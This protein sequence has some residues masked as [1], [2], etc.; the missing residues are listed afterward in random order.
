M[1]KGILIYLFGNTF[2]TELLLVLLLIDTRI[3]NWY[4]FFIFKIFC[5]SWFVMFYQFLLYNWYLNENFRNLAF[6]LISITFGK[7]TFLCLLF[8]IKAL[9]CVL[10]SLF[11]FSPCYSLVFESDRVYF[12]PFVPPS[13][14]INLKTTS[15]DLRKLKFLPVIHN[16]IIDPSVF[17]LLKLTYANL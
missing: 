2:I 15:F 12:L 14:I 11:L 10:F 13:V 6:L 8:F 1:R 9:S 17:Y 4:L 3:C 7:V 16:N 5:Y